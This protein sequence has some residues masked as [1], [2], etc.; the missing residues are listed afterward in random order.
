MNWGGVL[1]ADHENTAISQSAS[2]AAGTSRGVHAVPGHEMSAG[3]QELGV[4]VAIDRS[5]GSENPIK[6]R[7]RASSC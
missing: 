4:A 6:N 2:A 5:I 1:R 3:A 7:V